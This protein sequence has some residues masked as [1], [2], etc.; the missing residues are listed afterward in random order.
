MGMGRN[1][2]AAIAVIVSLT[3]VS[4]EGRQQLFGSS[5]II[6]SHKQWPSS[7]IQK[8]NVSLLVS[9]RTA[10]SS[11]YD[12][13][14]ALRGGASK[15][16]GK[17]A[18]TASGKKKVG[19]DKAAK[20]AES[21]PSKSITKLYTDTP[22]LT[23]IFITAILGSTILGYI[24]GEEN[25][26]AFL[27]LDPIRTIKGFEIWRP[28]TSASYLGPISMTWIISLYNLYTY[29]TRIETHYNR[30]NFLVFLVTQIVMLSFLSMLIGS[31]FFASA[32]IAAM[33]FVFSRIDPDG[34]TNWLVTRVPN[35]SLPYL[36]M[37][38]DS[39]QA[40]SLSAA[41]PHIIG[42]LSGHFFYFHREIWPKVGGEAW[43]EAPDVV[44][45]MIDPDSKSKTGK[46]AIAKALKA[47]KKGKG[48]KLGR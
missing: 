47:R 31:P 4:C 1:L 38:S 41:V 43:L 39:A 9:Q 35:W 3:A 29:G 16:K 30:S 24:L 10:S 23:R 22:L 17:T 5:S 37:V 18:R 12:A 36:M 42:I 32:M 6:V 11:S 20:R 28:F 34:Q 8:N 25:T 44:V 2:A 13:L 19:A 7:S 45:S 15:K 27:A 40:Q 14:L 21:G 26:Q 46:D 33:L 48:K